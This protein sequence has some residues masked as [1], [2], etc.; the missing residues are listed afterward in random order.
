MVRERTHLRDRPKAGSTA[1]DAKHR[2]GGDLTVLRL[3]SGVEL[4]TPKEGLIKF[5]IVPFVAGQGNRYAKPGEVYYERTFFVHSR[6]GPDNESYVCPLKEAN[7]PCPICE[8]RAKL[9]S[10]PDAD[11]KLFAKLGVKERQ[12]FLIRLHTA[13]GPENQVRVYESSYFCF[14]KLLDNYR[15]DAEEDESHVL[16]FDDYD[17]GSVLRVGY[18]EEDGGGF[19]FIKA[20][21]IDFKP[22]PNGLPDDVIDHG[23]CVDDLLNV[24]TYDELKQ[25]FLQVPGDREKKNEGSSKT[26]DQQPTNEDWDNPPKKEN[27][28]QEQVPEDDIPFEVSIYKQ[29]QKVRHRQFGIVTIL[30]INQDGSLNVIKPDDDVVKGV[31]PKNVRPLD[32]STSSETSQKQEKKKETPPMEK[33]A[34]TGDSWDDEPKPAKSRETTTRKPPAD[35]DWD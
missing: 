18:S 2:A 24:M 21:K 15:R 12:L 28:K 27:P 8:Y 3:P 19:K 23:I 30:R 4:F 6:V 1:R 13:E 32:D 25:S 14:G 20:Y 16:R 10:D 11:E 22:R 31:D 34:V 9:A 26:N 35:D 17:A 33:A 5:D 29:G 7:R